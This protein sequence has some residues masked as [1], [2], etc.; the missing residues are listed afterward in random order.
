MPDW[1]EP[2]Y[3]GDAVRIT[4]LE[5]NGPFGEEIGDVRIQH[6]GAGKFRVAMFVPGIVIELPGDTPKTEPEFHQWHI[7]KDVA[8][9]IFDEYVK[10]AIEG[11]WQ[12]RRPNA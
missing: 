7:D 12:E 10:C 8:D 1:T 9:E 4:M 6:Y 5:R 11:G 3:P 2:K